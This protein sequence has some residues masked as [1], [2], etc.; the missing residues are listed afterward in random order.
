ME[1]VS[2]SSPVDAMPAARAGSV[3]SIVASVVGPL[4][5]IFAAGYLTV[6]LGLSEMGAPLFDLSSRPVTVAGSWLQ[7]L[8]R[9]GLVLLALVAVLVYR[10]VCRTR[11][12][13]LVVLL[14]LLAAALVGAYALNPLPSGGEP[15]PIT[16]VSLMYGATSPFT[17]A[18]IGAVILDLVTAGPRT[19]RNSQ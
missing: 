11:A 12:A 3:L 9:A 15:H 6:Q 7:Y 5:V 1:K 14:V 8:L 13:R 17:L 10:S 4:L 19:R 2:N 16:W 18:L